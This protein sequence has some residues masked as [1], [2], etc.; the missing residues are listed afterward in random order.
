VGVEEPLCKPPRGLLKALTH[1][2]W[3]F[4]QTFNFYVQMCDEPPSK[5]PKAARGSVYWEVPT[6]R[7]M[8]TLLQPAAAMSLITSHNPHSPPPLS[9]KLFWGEAT[10]LGARDLG[11]GLRQQSWGW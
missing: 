9:A 10:R 5:K 6:K 2:V 1:Q 7:K 3:T 4:C 11:S 8:Q